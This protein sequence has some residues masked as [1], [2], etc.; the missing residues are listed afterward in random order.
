MCEVSWGGVE[1]TGLDF[2]GKEHKIN[3]HLFMSNGWAGVTQEGR[4][5][6]KVMIEEED[7]PKWWSGEIEFLT[8]T[9][10]YHHRVHSFILLVGWD[11]ITRKLRSLGARAIGWITDEREALV[12][13]FW[14]GDKEKL[15]VSITQ[16]SS[17]CITILVIESNNAFPL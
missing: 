11:F 6:F 12:E 9:Q 3:V 14:Y 15:Y 13:W 2:N 7:T 1:K 8:C 10:S 4:F 5:K 17:V 16:H